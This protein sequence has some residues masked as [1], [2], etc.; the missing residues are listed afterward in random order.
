MGPIR[1]ILS[2]DAIWGLAMSHNNL[3]LKNVMQPTTHLK[4]HSRMQ[5]NIDE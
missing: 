3:S 4:D 5:R 2:F 1:G